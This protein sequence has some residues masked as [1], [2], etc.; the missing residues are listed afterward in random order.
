MNR[1]EFLNIPIINADGQNQTIGEAIGYGTA[2]QPR[3]L[4][5]IEGRAWCAQCK[6]AP[7]RIAGELSEL[8][9][10][11]QAEP[12]SILYYNQLDSRSPLADLPFETASLIAQNATLVYSSDVQNGNQSTLETV[13]GAE[14]NFVPRYSLIDLLYAESP[15][16]SILTDSNRIDAESIILIAEAEGPEQREEVFSYL[17][18]DRAPDEVRI[19]VPEQAVEDAANL[20]FTLISDMETE[21]LTCENFTDQA[22]RTRFFNRVYFG[23]G[24]RP[25][26]RAMLDQIDQI[27]ASER[28]KN[29]VKQLAFNLTS[30]SLQ[31]GAVPSDV[32]VTGD[33]PIDWRFQ[34]PN[35]LGLSRDGA[36]E[37]NNEL[38]YSDATNEL[39]EAF[40]S[41]EPSDAIYKANLLTAYQR[42]WE[43]VRDLMLN[44]RERRR[45]SLEVRQCAGEE[46][47]PREPIAPKPTRSNAGVLAIGAAAIAAYFLSKRR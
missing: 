39:F 40:R 42:Y 3:F 13:L 43:D 33:E 24:G 22:A 10:F 2:I 15:N 25:E 16:A 14:G 18:G 27:D 17:S 46:L 19:G 31:V 8:E 44:P 26:L 11:D 35:I 37:V 34:L 45:L 1:Q 32:I 36:E 29:E 47:E 28:F 9:I 6:N 20:L 12:F 30:F 5:V 23:R 7:A 41:R 38:Y 21:P 4:V